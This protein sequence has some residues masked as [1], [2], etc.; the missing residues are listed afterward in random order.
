MGLSFWTTWAFS[1]GAALSPKPRLASFLSIR[2]SHAAAA[3]RPPSPLPPL[4]AVAWNGPYFCGRVALLQNLP[5]LVQ[6]GFNDLFLEFRC[7]FFVWHPLWHN[8]APH[9]L[10]SLSYCLTYVVLFS[11]AGVLSK[12]ASENDAD[13]ISYA[14]STKMPG[15]ICDISDIDKE[16]LQEYNVN[17]NIDKVGSRYQRFYQ[18][19]TITGGHYC[20]HLLKR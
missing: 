10:S 17:V 4:L 18:N 7:V 6:H 2:S 3:L 8:E 19:C 13:N 20:T 9:L 5:M 12:D 15:E 16:M 1:P 14:T 11:R